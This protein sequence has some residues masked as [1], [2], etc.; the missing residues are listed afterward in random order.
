MPETIASTAKS[1]GTRQAGLQFPV[2]IVGTGCHVPSDV[3]TNADL[4]RSLDTTDEWI[5]SRTGIRERR[6]LEAGRTTSDM[7]V[8]AARQALENSGRTAADIDAVIVA[9]FTYDQPLPSTALIVK[10]ALGAFN[11]FPLDLSQAACAGGVYGML[12]AAHLL[13][14]D[15]MR[16]VLV[17][18]AECLSRVTDP[19]DRSTRVFF[20]DAAGAVVMS[21]TD[22]GF[23]MLS[24]D[25]D[26]SLSYAVEIPSGGAS[27]PTTAQTVDERQQFLKMDGRAVWVEATK[28]LPE[29]IRATLDRAGLEPGDIDHYV[30]H[31]A[32]LNIVH[33]AMD[34][35]GVDRSRAGITVDKY[36][37]T[38]AATVFTVL[39]QAMERGDVNRGDLLVVSGIGAGF[40]WGTLCL[41]AG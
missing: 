25:L 19:E 12:T 6:W 8:A 28:R 3:V 40:I 17:I 5:V 22:P 24:W 36:G 10:E 26:A 32:N 18:G 13:Q 23:G 37:N 20:G 16:N 29:S 15:R 34:V 33:E 21:R 31:Q 14:N 1:S 11:A 2:G 30:L 27:L 39:H 41:R 35:L 38:G 4:V 7:C 9:T